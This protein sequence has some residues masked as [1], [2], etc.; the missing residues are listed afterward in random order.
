M[1]LLDYQLGSWVDKSIT[2]VSDD[3]SYFV[4]N[5]SYPPILSKN[6][7]IVEQKNIELIDKNNMGMSIGLLL[8]DFF[9][10]VIWYM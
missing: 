6:K 1:Y 4:I 3:W 2:E 5:E 10:A 8:T 7:L 9:F